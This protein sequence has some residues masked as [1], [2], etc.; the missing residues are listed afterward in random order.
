MD[1]CIMDGT[2]G[3]TGAVAL[4]SNTRNPIKLAYAVATG[5]Q[6]VLMVGNGAESLASAHG[7][8]REDTHYFFTQERYDQ[9]R[10]AREANA[11]TLDHGGA[12]EA[13]PRSYGTINPELLSTS[14]R[15]ATTDVPMT[16]SETTPYVVCTV[17]RAQHVRWTLVTALCRWSGRSR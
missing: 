6:H 1:A 5:T 2:T 11:V 12:L 8:Q 15:A 4:V 7:V 9:L 3:S 16:T 14:S 10:T 17:T 13:N